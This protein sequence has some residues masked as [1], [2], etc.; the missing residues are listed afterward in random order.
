M[1]GKNEAQG[2]IDA[3]ADPDARRRQD[4]KGRLLANDGL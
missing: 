3:V 4:L 2:P 1:A